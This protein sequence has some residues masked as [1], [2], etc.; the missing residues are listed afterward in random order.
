MTDLNSLLTGVSNTQKLLVSAS[1][2]VCA[3]VQPS[4]QTEK[5]MG[6]CAQVSLKSL[7]YADNLSGSL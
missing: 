7:N 3:A 6:L 1:Y 2:C 5:S 4:V